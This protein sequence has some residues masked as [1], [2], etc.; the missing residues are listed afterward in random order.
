M[1]WTV[2]DFPDSEE[3]FDIMSCANTIIQTHISILKKEESACERTDGRTRERKSIIIPNLT[4][5]EIIV[6]FPFDC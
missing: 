3:D 2:C 6:M 4:I 1:N 5:E